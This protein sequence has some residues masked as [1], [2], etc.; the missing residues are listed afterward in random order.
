MWTRK[1][2]S[3]SRK[4][5]KN[6][7]AQ[8]K[9]T[10]SSDH[11]GSSPERQVLGMSTKRQASCFTKGDLLRRNHE[12]QFNSVSYRYFCHLRLR[13]IKTAKNTHASQTCPKSQ[14]MGCDFKTQ[15]I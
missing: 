15:S 4:S 7:A 2:T 9:E 11:E 8:K 13:S 12:A 5:T 1:K 3:A 6:S 14:I 10:T